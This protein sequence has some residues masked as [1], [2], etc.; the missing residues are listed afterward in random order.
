MLNHKITLVVIKKVTS[1]VTRYRQEI[2]RYRVISKSWKTFFVLSCMQKTPCVTISKLV[3]R[4]DQSAVGANS[5]IQIKNLA[6]SYYAPGL[7]TTSTWKRKFVLLNFKR[8]E[9]WWPS[10]CHLML[11]CGFLVTSHRVCRS[12]LIILHF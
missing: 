4:K 12:S 7:K 3:I 11:R 5:S 6:R 9:N 2:T 10:S 8:H 1:C